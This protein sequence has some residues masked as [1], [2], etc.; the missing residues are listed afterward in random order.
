VLT[1]IENIVFGLQLSDYHTG[2]R[3]YSRR[4]LETVNFYSNSDN[5]IF[6]QELIAQVVESGFRIREIAIP[7]RYFPEASSASLLASARY[8]L[9]ILWLMLRYLLHNSGLIRQKQFD[10]LK[11]RYTK[12][13]DSVT[14]VH[15][16]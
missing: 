8:G 9:G 1:K 2:Y 6:D 13:G 12:A 5:F 7:T 3:A 14:G 15:R 10:S 11:L 4:V 16:T